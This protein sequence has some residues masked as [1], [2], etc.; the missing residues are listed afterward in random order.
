MTFL[1]GRIANHNWVVTDLISLL[2]QEKSWNPVQVS[3]DDLQTQALNKQIIALIGEQDKEQAFTQAQNVV[4]LWQ[5]TGIFSHVQGQTQPDISKLQQDLKLLGF[6]TLPDN[7]IQELKTK[8]QAYFQTYAQQIMNPFNKTSLLAVDQDWLSFSRYTLT[9]ALTSSKVQWDMSSGFLYLEHNNTTYVVLQATLSD[10]DIIKEQS[11]LLEVLKQ[12]REQVRASSAGKFLVTGTSIFAAYTQAQAQAE[13]TIMSIVG[14]ILTLGLLLAIFRS[15]KILWLYL[16]IVVGLVCGV[17]ATVLVF[18]QIHIMTL[19][20]GTSLIG[21]LIDFP[22]HWLMGSFFTA[23]WQ[24]KASMQALQKTFILSLIITLLG[25][26][27]LGI[28]VLPILQQTALFSAVAL[29]FAVIT[30]LFWLPGRF[31][32]YQPKPLVKLPELTEVTCFY[33]LNTKVKYLLGVGVLILGAIGIYRSQWHDNMRQWIA[34]PDSM[35]IQAQQ[36]AN[37]T[38]MD[39][40]TQYLLITANSPEALLD[41]NAQVTAQL[42]QLQTQN[43]EI[44]F[45]SLSNWLHTQSKQKALA[46]YLSSH[47][48]AQDYAIL[49]QIGIPASKIQQ[50]LTELTQTQPVSLT[51]ALATSI[52]QAWQYLYLGELQPQVYGA[53]IKFPGL[54]TTA[55][56]QVQ[57]LANNQDVFWQ[58]KAGHLNESFKHT[59]DQAAWLKIA[60]FVLAFL[61]LWKFFGVKKTAKMLL[62]PLAAIGLTIATLGWFNVPIS[63]FA[64]FGLLLV[65]A[66]GI[67]YTVYLETVQE[68]KKYKKTAVFFAALTTMIAFLLLG[69]SSTPAVSAFG[70]SVSLGVF[71]CVLIIFLSYKDY[72]TKQ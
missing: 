18:G 47:I 69:I 41:K 63:L 24:A 57:A 67:D 64:M 15:L 48:Q 56:S 26:I 7:V 55:L 49:E 62:L 33:S 72:Q 11:S 2:P 71:Y 50:A 10:G 42:Q 66:I 30:T 38:G 29:I 28:T 58:D 34:V 36:I 9:S 39:L 59:R 19:V 25:Y 60:S 27:L 6:A 52:G 3:A 1:G 8:P 53:V 12:T 32:R 20:I 23:N 14:T 70:L 51:Q 37:Y 40:S 13:S 54:T 22:L 4:K 61:F 21:V 31:A 17:S 5:Q 35:L 45:L 44:K 46:E 65:S 68:K 43:P 16:P